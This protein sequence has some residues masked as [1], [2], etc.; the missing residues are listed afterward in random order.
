MRLEQQYQELVRLK[1]EINQRLNKGT[2]F[3]KIKE[4]MLYLAQDLAYS[5]LKLKEN[6]LIMLECFF[7][8]WLQEKKKLPDLGVK[9]DIFYKIASLNDVEWKYQRIKYCG[10]R[11]ENVVPE[12][13][14]EQAIEWIIE[15]KV[16]GIAIGKII[17]FETQ[18]KQ[19]NLLSIAR[20]I[21][22]RGDSFNAL[23][24]LQYANETFPG[25]EKLLLEEADI[26][27]DGGQHRK[28][29]EILGK[30]ENPTS[31]IREL[32]TELQQVAGND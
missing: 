14:I 23:L 24:I 7:N 26:W 22:E 27:L 28:A 11:I 10:L 13:Y 19:N 31:E 16:S 29:L 6:Q 18:N 5:K 8:I 25:W 9:T 15:D 17:V 12:K 32:I 2:D 30:I 3:Q 4:L 20:C 1:R 21:R